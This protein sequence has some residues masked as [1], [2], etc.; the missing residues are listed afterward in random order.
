V[1]LTSS[2]PSFLRRVGRPEYGPA[3]E[4]RDGGADLKVGV[5][6]AAADYIAL[7]C[8]VLVLSLASNAAWLLLLV[9]PARASHWAWVNFLGPWFFAGGDDGGASAKRRT[10]ER[11][12]KQKALRRRA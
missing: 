10:G 7:V 12:A 3:G 9:V 11:D 1:P 2:L 5:A 4:L 6:E 8:G